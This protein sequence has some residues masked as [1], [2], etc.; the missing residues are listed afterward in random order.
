MR[1]L[2]ASM[3]DESILEVMR[4]CRREFDETISKFT[5]AEGEIDYTEEVMKDR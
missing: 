5:Y 2:L 4:V 1:P 3:S